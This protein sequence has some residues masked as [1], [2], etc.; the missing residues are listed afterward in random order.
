MALPRP[1][2]TRANG[3]L[4]ARGLLGGFYGPNARDQRAALTWDFTVE[5]VRGIEPHCQL[6]KSMALFTADLVIR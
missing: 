1:S 4:M 6:G 3:T 2:C 5:R